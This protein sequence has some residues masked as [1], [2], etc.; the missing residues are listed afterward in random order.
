MNVYI[1]WVLEAYYDIRGFTTNRT[2][3]PL[4]MPHGYVLLPSSINYTAKPS[5]H[6]YTTM[7]SRLTKWG[8]ESPAKRA[9]SITQAHCPPAERPAM[10]CKGGKY[11]GIRYYYYYSRCL[12]G[13]IDTEIF[14]ISAPL[15][16]PSRLI[17]PP[18]G[19]LVKLNSWI[20]IPAV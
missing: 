5:A 13:E 20:Y 18:T 7:Q 17:N 14:I 11:P 3:S 19:G 10:A 8:K 4:S 12:A 16:S 9:Y 2:Q 1:H 6:I 15:I